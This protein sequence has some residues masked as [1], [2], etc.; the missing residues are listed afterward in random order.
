V[1]PFI[2]RSQDPPRA[3]ALTHT[4][5]SLRQQRSVGTDGWQVRVSKICYPLAG[6]VLVQHFSI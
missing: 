2:V 5:D 3:D 4:P 6:L 1:M